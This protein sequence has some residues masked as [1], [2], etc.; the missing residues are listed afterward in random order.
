M[1]RVVEAVSDKLALSLEWDA[2]AE[3]HAPLPSMLHPRILVHVYNEAVL[4]HRTKYQP[5]FLRALRNDS[6]FS[7]RTF[8]MEEPI[9]RISA[10][11]CHYLRMVYLV[12]LYRS[13]HRI[14]E[15][16]CNMNYVSLSFTNFVRF[17]QASLY[18]HG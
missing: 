9:T 17:K 6:M 11:T 10:H 4:I 2:A 14:R 18:L 1:V 12:V 3:Y 15:G 7:M 16:P 13:L 5:S 8:I